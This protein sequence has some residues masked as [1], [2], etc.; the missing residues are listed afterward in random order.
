MA[1]PS[2]DRANLSGEMSRWLDAAR[3]GSPEALGRAL[4]ACR[5]YLVRV[6]ARGIPAHLRAK[7]EP[8]DAV[9][10]AFL[11]AQRAFAGFPGRTE[12]DLLAWLRRILLNALANQRRRFRAGGK[13][14]AGREVSLS[15]LSAVR[16]FR[17][18]AHG[19][20][21]RC[22]RRRYP[23]G[24]EGPKRCRMDRTAPRIRPTRAATSSSG[25]G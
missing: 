24:V 16:F 20:P 11:H 5:P 1:S 18:F 2:D 7:L 6:A 12:A 9:Q 13:R 4:E 14:Q 19:L 15:D 10:E 3:Q 22:S 17:R 21:C 25:S 23:M 8:A